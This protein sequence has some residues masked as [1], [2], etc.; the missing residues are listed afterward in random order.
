M[1]LSSSDPENTYYLCMIK[2]T[3]ENGKQDY[4]NYMI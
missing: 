3:Q 2:P 1:R 4:S